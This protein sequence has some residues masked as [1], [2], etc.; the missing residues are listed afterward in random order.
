M[1][2]VVG[3]FPLRRQA[4]NCGVSGE[5]GWRPMLYLAKNGLGGGKG[6]LAASRKEERAR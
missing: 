1:A 5:R 4:D 6:T 3:C 2:P